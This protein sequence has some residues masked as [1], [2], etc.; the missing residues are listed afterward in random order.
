[1]W[2]TLGEM[3]WLLSCMTPESILLRNMA[4]ESAALNETTSGL[5]GMLPVL[6][7]ADVLSLRGT[8]VVFT[9]D[10]IVNGR[11][12][13]QIPGGGFS[14]IGGSIF[15]SYRCWCVTGLPAALTVRAEI[16]NIR[17]LFFW[18]CAN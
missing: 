6:M 3:A 2:P 9:R 13:R 8:K 1:M 15:N 17:F 14:V 11:K 16:R 7:A 12:I 10:Q 18:A 4:P 5:S